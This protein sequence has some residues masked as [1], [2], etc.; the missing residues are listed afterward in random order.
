MYAM[1]MLALRLT[2]TRCNGVSPT[3][4]DSSRHCRPPALATHTVHQHH[5]ILPSSLLDPRA[6][7]RN[8]RPERI[9]PVVPHVVQVADLDPARS[10]L[11][12]KRVG[13]YLAVHRIAVWRAGDE[14]FADRDDVGDAERVEHGGVPRVFPGK[15]D[16]LLASDSGPV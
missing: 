2:P 9:V 11:G 14:R 12:R 3:R 8:E 13:A 15:R 6:S 16:Q 1:T 4:P 10:V 5:A 7:L